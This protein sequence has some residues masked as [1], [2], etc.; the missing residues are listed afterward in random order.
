MSTPVSCPRQTARAVRWRHRVGWWARASRP[1]IRPPS[2][3]HAIRFEELFPIKQETTP[4]F[5][6]FQD[7][8]RTEL[9]LSMTFRRWAKPEMHHRHSHSFTTPYQRA[10]PCIQFGPARKSFSL[11]DSSFA[12]LC[13]C[14]DHPAVLAV[15]DTDLVTLLHDH[16]REVALLRSVWQASPRIEHDR[17]SDRP[18]VF[19]DRGDFFGR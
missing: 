16:R 15:R 5:I 13:V 3:R 4:C 18:R 14:E 10:K 17:H 6:Q 12:P 9:A 1:L 8:L 2:A 19:A 7:L 11:V